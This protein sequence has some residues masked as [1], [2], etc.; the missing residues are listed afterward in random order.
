[1]FE[2]KR[3]VHFYVLYALYVQ[4]RELDTQKSRAKYIAYIPE[5][6]IG[7]SAQHT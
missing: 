1:M 5:I 6:R 7:A 3:K 2:C 4:E